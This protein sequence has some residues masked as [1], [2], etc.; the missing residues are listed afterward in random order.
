VITPPGNPT[1]RDILGVVCMAVMIGACSRAERAKRPVDSSVGA[2]VGAGV[3]ANVGAGVGA[4]M[5]AGVGASLDTA[6]GIV[7]R[8]GAEPQSR[9]ALFSTLGEASSPLALSGAPATEL[10]AA[11]GLEVMVEGRRTAERDLLVAPG[12]AAVFQVQRF[13]VRASDGVEARDGVLREIDGAW[14][15][16]TAPGVRQPIVGLPAALRGQA[17]A[18]VFLVGTS[19][20][21]PQAFG[22]L[23]P[24]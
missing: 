17:G 8:V 4:N 9:L 18:R 14:Y 3:G 24:R 23:R 11:E 6:R 21:A 10:A 20:Q 13:A 22:V 5:G 19:A 1:L 2:N 7:R 15:L 12:G 16:E